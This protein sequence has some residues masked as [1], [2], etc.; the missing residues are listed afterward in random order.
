MAAA[1]AAAASQ[2]AVAEQEAVAA[3]VLAQQR[4][5]LARQ[6]A[7]GA[8]FGTLEAA[9]AAGK[10]HEARVKEVLAAAAAKDIDCSALGLEYKTPEELAEWVESNGV[11]VAY[12]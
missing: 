8:G 1:R 5:L 3:K 7:P 10:V 12:W 2:A 9:G 11:E 4:E 6:T